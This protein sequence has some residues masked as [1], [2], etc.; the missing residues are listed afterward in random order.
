MKNVQTLIVVYK[1]ELVMNFLRKMVE[2][3]D[4][5][6]VIIGTEDGTV[7]IVPWIEK[8]W[9]QNKE[10]GTIDSKILLLNN[11]KG[12]KALEPVIDVKFNKYGVKYGWAGKQAL[13]IVNEKDLKKEEYDEFLEEFKK[14][15]LPEKKKAHK[16][17]KVAEKLATAMLD[18]VSLVAA[19]LSDYFRDKKKV[20]QQLLLYGVAKLYENDLETFMK[21]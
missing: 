6:D 2:T 13:L 18:P 12:F 17:F 9:L 7:T 21:S 5:T 10:A 19:Y 20:R 15:A 11:I 4:D 8:V 14:L 16:K 3:D 1:D